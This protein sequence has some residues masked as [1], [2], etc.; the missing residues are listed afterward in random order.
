MGVILQQLVGS[1]H[2][3]HFYPNCAGVVRSY[4]FYPFGHMKPEEGVVCVALGLGKLVVEGGE[5]LRFCPANPQVLPQLALGEKF[6]DQSQ[7]G[8][9]AIDLSHSEIGPSAEDEGIVVRL[10]LEAAENH[11][12]LAPVGS[13]WSIENKAF[14]DGIQRPGV[15]VVTFAHILKSDLFPLADI[16]RRVVELGRQG[17]GGPVEIEFAANLNSGPREF[18]I[19]Q[20]RPYG[21]GQDAE[22]VAIDGLPP[23]YLVCYSPRAM[24]NGLVDGIRDIVYVKPDRFNAAKTRFIAREVGAF[25]ETL[26]AADRGYLLIGPGRWG[27]AD[28]WLGIPVNWEQIS[29]ARIIVETS[30]K[31]FS[32]DPSQG[33]HFF[34]NLTSFG[35]AYLT[36][37]P[38]PDQGFIDWDWLGEQPVESEAEFVRHVRLELPLEARIDGRSSQAAVLKW[39]A[40]CAPQ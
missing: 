4:N 34:H 35:I 7:R 10:D 40:R 15:R 18:A 36:V 20:I 39:S 25:N 5:T 21:A 12:T 17:M 33:S 27:S 2:E 13:V 1:R 32:V 24:G 23:E 28:P 14:Y 38:G 9:Y 30:L 3:Q 19:L 26:R 8:F 11:G 6:I 29:A 22:P 16:L 31:D 37:R